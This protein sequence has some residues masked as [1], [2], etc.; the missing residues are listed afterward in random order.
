[1]ER[2]DKKVMEDYKEKLFDLI[3]SGEARTMKD[4]EDASLYYFNR[5][6]NEGEDH[7]IQIAVSRFL[8]TTNY[9]HPF[10]VILPFVNQFLM[11]YK[12]IKLSQE[13]IANWLRAECGIGNYKAFSED[14]RKELENKVKQHNLRIDRLAGRANRK[15]KE[16]DINENKDDD[17]VNEQAEEQGS[18]WVA[19]CKKF[20]SLEDPTLGY[21]KLVLK[22][23]KNP[24]EELSAERKDAVKCMIRD[25]WYAHNKELVDSVSARLECG[26]PMTGADLSE[27]LRE[28][29]CVETLCL[30]KEAR[31]SL[32]HMTLTGRI[33]K[34]LVLKRFFDWFNT[35]KWFGPPTLEYSLQ[36]IS[37]VEGID[38]YSISNEIKEEVRNMIDKKTEEIE[39]R[40]KVTQEIETADKSNNEK[41]ADNPI[42]KR[43]L[44]SNLVC[45]YHFIRMRE[46]LTFDEAKS[47]FIK[48]T[49]WAW[50]DIPQTAKDDIKSYI[51]E[52]FEERKDWLLLKV[53]EWAKSC[54][55]SSLKVERAWVFLLSQCCISY[56]SLD[57]DT[58]TKIKDILKKRNIT[59]AE[60]L[61]PRDDKGRFVSKKNSDER[62]IKLVPHVYADSLNGVYNQLL[63]MEEVISKDVR[64][65]VRVMLFI[66]GA[67]CL[68]NNREI[69]VEELEALLKER[70]GSSCMCEVL[71]TSED[72]DGKTVVAVRIPHHWYFT[73]VRNDLV[74]ITLNFSGKETA[75]DYI[76]YPEPR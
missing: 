12:Y 54:S 58:K 3:R 19:F 47:A 32:F 16:D 55:E 18:W 2:K 45:C 62:K 52:I 59:R 36:H 21:I 30:G 15:S 40:G 64:D 6:L 38:V 4:L 68:V 57:E 66:K 33:Y 56:E 67:S 74:T 1:M 72:T 37:K 41:Y 70:F 43:Y 22:D 69:T 61:Q 50:E 11:S 25:Y 65:V 31:D 75:P 20:D 28:Q 26:V 49:G 53:E 39:S 76:E 17:K 48:S 63:L 13:D 44:D 51:H 9:E 7:G 71:A 73:G 24:W 23:Y 35:F 29:Y 5:D 14:V 60:D 46:G 10:N 42:T 27:L 34:D 8:S